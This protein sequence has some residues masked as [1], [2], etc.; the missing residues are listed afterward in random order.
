[1]I[2]PYRKA[3]LYGCESVPARQRTT[4]HANGNSVF[5]ICG[6][7]FLQHRVSQFRYLKLVVSLA[8]TQSTAGNAWHTLRC[9][10]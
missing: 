9:K 2:R 3:K 7:R 1:M 8:R 6:G 10:L 5:P 4:T